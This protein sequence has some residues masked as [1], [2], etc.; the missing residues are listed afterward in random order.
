MRYICSEPH[1]C[2]DFYQ[3]QAA[4]IRYRCRCVVDREH[5]EGYGIVCYCKIIQR[6]VDF[7]LE[8]NFKDEI[9]KILEI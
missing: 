1:A 2:D 8:S 4:K 6:S 5:K 3:H 9:D 7:K